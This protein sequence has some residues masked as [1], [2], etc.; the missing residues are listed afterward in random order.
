VR[1]V[2]VRVLRRAGYRVLE[3]SGGAEALDLH[4]REERPV[5][6]LLTDVV[7]PGMNGRQVADQLRRRQGGLRVLFVSGFVDGLMGD[8]ADG[9]EEEILGKPFTPASL[10][11]RVRAVLDRP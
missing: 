4:A 10:L 11:A 3:A 2:T 8:G 5:G 7:M 1:G 6:L 9:V